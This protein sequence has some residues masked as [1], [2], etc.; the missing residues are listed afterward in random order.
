MTQESTSWHNYPKIYNLGHAA[1]S[2]LFEGHVVI[3]E[4]IDGSQFSFGR[5]GDVLK[6]RSKG[7]NLDVD[8]PEKMFKVAIDQVKKRFDLLTDGLTYRAEYLQ[9]PKHNALAYDRT[10]TDNIIIFDINDAE[11]SYLTLFEKDFEA[12]RLGFEVVPRYSLEQYEAQSFLKLLDNVSVLGGQKIEGFVIKNYRQ[13][14]PDKKCLM[15]KFVSE[16]F[17][18]VHKVSWKSENPGRSD[19]LAS[20]ILAYKHPTRW[21]KAVQHIREKGELQNSVKDIGFLIKE[22][23]E[24]IKI[25][26]GDEIKEILFKWAWNKI[27]RGIV[28]GIPEWYKEQ[29]L[30]KRFEKDPSLVVP[31]QHIPDSH[32]LDG[33]RYMPI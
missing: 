4:K 21:H 16:A 23:A 33:P 10:P 5:F 3:E 18:E 31:F 9:K 19:I 15:G 2:D 20:L 1:L 24:D 29:L 13:F 17:K 25:E 6:A 28:G 7:Q 8:H 11:E 30:I 32:C 14:G 22:V 26:C 12:G 27:Q